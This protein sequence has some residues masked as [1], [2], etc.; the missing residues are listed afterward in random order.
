MWPRLREDAG[1]SGGLRV[2]LARRS[3][4]RCLCAGT[5]E[6]QVLHFV[7]DD[8]ILGG[9]CAGTNEKQVLHFVQD[10]NILGGRCAGANEK[11][12]LHFVQDDSI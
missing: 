9:R 5:S 7:Q 10:D 3:G 4:L 12:V 6:K 1:R 11:Q 2:S 8:N